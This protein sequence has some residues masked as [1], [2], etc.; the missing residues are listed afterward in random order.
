M[1]LYVPVGVLL[2]FLLA[3][4][5]APAFA[6]ASEGLVLETKIALADAVGRIDHLA[7]DP[8]RNRL[9]VAELGNNS[10]GVIDI[11]QRRLVHRITGLKE[12]QGVAYDPDSDTIYVANA[13]DGSVDR[14]KGAD[15][16]PLGQLKLGDD[17]DNIRVDAR[18]HQIVIG[19]GHGALAIIDAG[20]ARKTG[21]I[22]LPAHPES[23]QLEKAGPR[24][25]INVP[26]ARQ[27]S[28]MDRSTGRQVGAWML[29]DAQANF[30]MA[31]DDTDTRLMVVYRKPAVLAVFDARSGDLIARRPTC[32]DADDVFFDPRRQRI[33]IS[34]GE[35]FLDVLQWSGDAVEALARLP[36]VAGARTSI[37]VQELDRLF[38]AVR[39]RGSEGAALWVYRPTP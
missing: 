39:A 9:L 18:T 22:R 3:T 27:V 20:S 24:I 13:G 31:L 37:F 34:C 10:V 17:A 8:A 1:P 36:T 19:Y 26:D 16:T 30:P 32:G 28:V 25:F 14:F 23:F 33:Y 11:A 29:P 7:F 4:M 6:G 38:L 2:A 5:S 12:P 15:L 21:D 35:G